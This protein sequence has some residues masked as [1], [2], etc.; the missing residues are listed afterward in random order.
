MNYDVWRQQVRVDLRAF[1]QKLERKLREAPREELGRILGQ[2]EYA[3]V[4]Y[5]R[6]GLLQEIRFELFDH[7]C[8][9]GDDR[10][11]AREV[12]R[13]LEA[14]A[15]LPTL[16]RLEPQDLRITRRVSQPR[17]SRSR[18][19]ARARARGQRPAKVGAALA[20][21]IAGGTLVVR[22]WPV[23][24]CLAGAI[25]LAATGALLRQGVRGGAGE[26]LEVPA[27]PT[28]DDTGELLRLREL[29]MVGYLDELLADVEAQVQALTRIGTPS[30]GG[31]AAGSQVRL[32]M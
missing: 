3:Y 11:T 5:Y 16:P 12:T 19:S 26:A 4:T 24:G 21:T 18:R 9:L 14:P 20:V 10:L 27:P 17:L 1:Y 15:T 28:P 8:A 6:N 13:R 7:L 22:G 29:A 31:A 25:G 23:V 2:D 30:A 32:S